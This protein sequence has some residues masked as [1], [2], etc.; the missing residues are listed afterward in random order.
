MDVFILGPL[1]KQTSNPYENDTPSDFLRE[2]LL[3]TLAEK[4]PD[5]KYFLA[6]YQAHEF[7]TYIRIYESCCN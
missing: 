3:T 2:H 6:F 1:D 4:L 5:C 7:C